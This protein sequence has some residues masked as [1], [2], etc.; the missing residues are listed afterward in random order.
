MLWII[1]DNVLSST[2]LV[3]VPCYSTHSP[4]VYAR[5]H[6]YSSSVGHWWCWQVHHSPRPL[7]QHH[8]QHCWLYVDLPSAMTSYLCQ[9]QHTVTATLPSTIS[10]TY[11]KISHLICTR[12]H[13][14]IRLSNLTGRVTV[15]VNFTCITRTFML[16]P[17]SVI[18]CFCPQ[19][20]IL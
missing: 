11:C 10:C 6:F 12:V 8:H 1:S 18:V 20:S 4:S 5:L 15:K 16:Y 17:G 19:C 7:C 13:C 14:T 3:L 2:Y 9:T